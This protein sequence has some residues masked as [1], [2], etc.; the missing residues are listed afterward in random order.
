MRQ[1]FYRTDA[2]MIITA[3]ARSQ[4]RAPVKTTVYAD[5]LFCVNFI[6]DYVMLL[7]VKRLTSLDVRRRRLMLGALVGGLG[8]FAVLLPPL[9]FV[10]SLLISVGEAML[11][12]VAAFLPMSIRGYIRSAFL[13][14]AVS[15]TYCGIMTAV[16]AIASPEGLAVRN[17]SVYIGISPFV[18]I[19]LTALCYFALRLFERIRGSDIKCRKCRVIVSSRG[20]AV[21]AEGI[22]DTGSTL[23]EP[24]SGDLV[25]V[26]RSKLFS[27]ISGFGEYPDTE[28]CGN[29]ANIRMVPF[30][31][32]G[33][34]GVLPAFRPDK[35]TVVTAGRKMS[36]RAYIAL[37][38]G[39]NLTEGCDVIVPAE[40]IMKGS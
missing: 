8:S 30:S 2:I 18:L 7:S 39:N 34:S 13:L 32:V 1:L 14:F 12:T 24:F 40:L 3:F 35:I 10:I 5:V 27:D 36:V 11:M 22:A 31:S 37:S 21:E 33:G 6:V 9:P 15:F 23:R 19:A 17:S 28:V 26:G 4:R 20:R 25:I 38:S 16:L 29:G